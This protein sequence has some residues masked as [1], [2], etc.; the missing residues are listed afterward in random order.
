MCL[1]HSRSPGLA[2]KEPMLQSRTDP[3]LNPGSAP[4]L[5]A[6]P[7]ELQFP[8]CGDA[9]RTHEIIHAQDL[10]QLLVARR[11][12]G[13]RDLS[14]SSHLIPIISLSPTPAADGQ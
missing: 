5:A 8:S 4:Q 11:L 6:F 14:Q 13:A 3:G 10:A 12:L 1:L 9:A 2:P 7:L